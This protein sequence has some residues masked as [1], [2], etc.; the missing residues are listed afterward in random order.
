MCA[1]R[2]DLIRSRVPSFCAARLAGEGYAVRAFGAP[3]HT[4]ADSGVGR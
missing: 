4:A 3:R 1:A 2:P